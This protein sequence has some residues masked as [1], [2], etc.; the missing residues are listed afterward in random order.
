MKKIERYYFLLAGVAIVLFAISSSA[1]QG[2]M[3]GDYGMH[4]GYGY[5][6]GRTSRPSVQPIDQKEAEAIL[7]DYIRATEN[8]NLKPG[9]I[10]DKGDV[11]EAKIVT[12]DDSLVDKIWIDK[13]T[14]WVTNYY[15]KRYDTM[16]PGSSMHYG[17]GEKWNF[18]PYC[19]S[20]INP[21]WHHHGGPG[22]M[23][24]GHD[25]GYGMHHGMRY[26]YDQP[27]RRWKKPVDKKDA[28]QML[29][30]YL[31]FIGNPNLTLGKIEETDTLF[32]GE[33]V[34][35]KQKDLVNK[36]TIDKQTGRMQ[37]VY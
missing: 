12:K 30:N 3:Y 24:Y 15:N 31:E 9:S 25:M 2:M 20:D 36:I 37:S 16:Q 5:H 21:D 22:M 34:T 18:C 23:G 32:K 10:T 4:Q 28:E 8:P 33:I 26:E 14:G 7:K 6:H 29:K 13:E 27:Y 35:K 17:R 19:G 11:F 1:Q